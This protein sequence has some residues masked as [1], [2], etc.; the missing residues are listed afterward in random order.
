MAVI[1]SL[2]VK[3]GLVTVE[4]DQATAKAKQDAKHLQ[5]SFDDLTGGL[6]SLGAGF[7]ALGGSMGVGA[8]GFAALMH[9]TLEFSNHIKDLADGFEVT[10]GQML[11][12][13]NALKTSGANADNAAKMIGKLFGKISEAK[14]GNE[15]TI[16]Q[17]EKLGI[18]FKELS[19][20]KPDEA[21]KRVFDGMANSGL[22]AFD[23]A[24]M[25]K[26]MLGKGGIGVS[27]DEVNEKLKKSTAEYDA[28]AKAIAKMGEVSDNL[29]TTLTNLT[30][31]FTDMIA[32]F[33]GDGIVSVKTF[34]NILVAL[35]AAATVAG[36]IRIATAIGTLTTAIR[37]LGTTSAVTLAVTSPIL[38]AI[39]AA[40]ALIA[41]TVSDSIETEKAQ[42]ALLETY[43]KSVLD[44]GKPAEEDPAAKAAAEAAAAAKRRELN[45][46]LSKIL[47]ARE[48]FDIEGKIGQLKVDALRG[49]E[50]GIK[51]QE[52]QLTKDAELAKSK[53]QLK[54]DLN[55][56][57]V[58]T[59]EG[60]LFAAQKEARDNSARQK[61][62]QATNLLKEQYKIE[63]QL[64]TLKL[65][66]TDTLVAYDKE[67]AALKMSSLSIEKYSVDIL[68]V[69]LTRRKALADIESRMQQ[70]LLK[71]NTNLQQKQHITNEANKQSALANQ[72]A[73]EDATYIAAT[74]DRELESIAR[75]GN[76]DKLNI[77]FDKQRIALGTESFNMRQND[78]RISQ[79]VL[80][81]NK[82]LLDIDLQIASAQASM[83][84]GATFEAE[85]A[86]LE[87]LKDL[88]QELS[89]VRKGAIAIDEQRRTSFTLGWENAMKKFVE[90]SEGLGQ[91]GSDAFNSLVN[92]M[93]NAI[94]NFVKTGKASFKDFAKSLIQDIMAMILKFQ[95]MQLVM[96]GLRAMGF[97]MPLGGASLPAKATGGDIDS[98]TI[99]G[100]NGPE[101]FIPSRRGTVIPNIQ[102]TQSMGNQPS[103]VYNGPYI[104]SMSAIDT[105]SA[106]QFLVQNKAA[107][108]AANQSASR[109]IP[110]S[111]N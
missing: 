93:G 65:A 81:T 41:Y 15:S 7:A 85:K 73:K 95:A 5:K 11:Q 90:N 24:R 12:F 27:L 25:V 75:K 59:D 63:G 13:D 79:E 19:T 56:E 30:L 18:S 31:A 37:L 23:K 99:V 26:E 52:I 32:P 91:V 100:E 14:G 48:L 76:A 104:A 61:A 97:N 57:Y 4:W 69:E 21:I 80:E 87:K 54:Q 105:Q 92:N 98:P 36:V 51:L 70:D 77:D 53:A 17:F 50:Y 106:T 22:N 3:L 71:A 108:W 16:A 109:S 39:V 2:T 86:R 29:K 10:V 43:K 103:I 49:D 60:N 38:A 64:I 78:F 44:K 42:L 72:K 1:G 74:R 6:K 96:M 94:D 83:G 102:A 40:A 35:G 82:R 47:L 58:S 45:A 34:H 46:G 110:T 67:S 89:N 66:A 8:L 9:K 68:N 101:I 62:D 84:S 28:H 20:M 55:K 107:I 33:S 111:R 88:E